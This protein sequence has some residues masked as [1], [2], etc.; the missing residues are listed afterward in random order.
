MSKKQPLVSKAKKAAGALAL[1]FVF[2]L[3]LFLGARWVYSISGGI[4]NRQVFS[5]AEI[6]AMHDETCATAQDSNLQPFNEP[7]ISVTFDDGWESIYSN[8]FA[9]LEQCNIKTTQYILAEH[10]ADKAYLSEAQVRSLQNAGH[11]M[12]SHTMTHPDLTT[13]SEVEA[14][15]ELS[16]SGRILSEKFGKARDF[17]SPLGATNS[18]VMNFIKKHYRSH[19]NTVGDPKEI[20]DV[21]INLSETF[22][23][24]NINAFTIRRST[25]LEEVKKMIDYTI[26]RKGWLVITYHQVDGADRSDFAVSPEELKEQLRL[27]KN[28]NISSATIGQVLDAIDSREKDG[29]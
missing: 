8:G 4:D 5:Q 14:D 17:A 11:E 7:I 28:S 16:E 3:P 27:I 1:L 25:T 20:E 23:R 26:A 18:T 6:D 10:F 9:I 13:L 2:L 19:R 29:V 12:A 15:W 21:D 24:Y 22:D